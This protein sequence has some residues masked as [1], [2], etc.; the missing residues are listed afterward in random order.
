MYL[1]DVVVA[2]AWSGSECQMGR[3]GTVIDHELI[4]CHA[5]EGAAASD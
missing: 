1:L 5:F 2:C 3:V 4:L